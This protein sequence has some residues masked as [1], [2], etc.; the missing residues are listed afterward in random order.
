MFMSWLITFIFSSLAHYN[1]VCPG[2]VGGDQA[3]LMDVKRVD[4]SK[5]HG[6]GINLNIITTL[7]CK[8]AL[9]SAHTT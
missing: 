4:D 5:V 3:N 7:Y 1:N 8:Y 2:S 9:K 6:A